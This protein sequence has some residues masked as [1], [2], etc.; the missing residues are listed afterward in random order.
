MTEWGLTHACKSGSTYEKSTH[1][2]YQINRMTGGKHM[3]TSTDA[4]KGLNKIQH[5]II[6]KKE[7]LGKLGIKKNFLSTI[8]S[9]CESPTANIILDDEKT[10]SFSPKISDKTRT[11]AFT[12][13]IQFCT[14]CS[15]Q[16]S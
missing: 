15:S 11:A 8:T 6:T 2:I 14:G 12:I 9:T 7:P 13:A 10:E 1:V 16:V 3:I 4:E 5:C